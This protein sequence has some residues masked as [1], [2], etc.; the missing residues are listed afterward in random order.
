VD[1]E[2]VKTKENP[3][4]KIAEVVEDISDTREDPAELVRLIHDLF[5]NGEGPWYR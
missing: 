4:V 2:E 1:V 5:Y 3:E